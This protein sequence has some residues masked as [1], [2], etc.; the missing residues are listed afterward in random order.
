M[1]DFTEDSMGKK[2]TANCRPQP[3]RNPIEWGQAG[4]LRQLEWNARSAEGIKI[5]NSLR[6][7]IS[8][9]ATEKLRLF[10]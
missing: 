2:L 5:D 7:E 3:G 9:P 4:R 10:A 6:E 8:S 1:H